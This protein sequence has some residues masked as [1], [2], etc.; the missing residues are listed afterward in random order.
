MR[1]MFL[2]LAL[3]MTTSSLMADTISYDVTLDELDNGSYALT[4][5]SALFQIRTNGFSTGGMLDGATSPGLSGGFDEAFPE[6]TLEDYLKF[7]YF[8]ILQ[9]LDG[10][11]NVIDSSFIVALLPGSGV[12][13]LVQDLFPY[14]EE[15]LVGAFVTFDS[16][17]FID[18]LDK[19]PSSPVAVGD[20]AIPSRSGETLDLIAFIG[21]IDGNEGVKVGTLSF[22]V[23]PEVSSI[24]STSILA[25]MGIAGYAV[26]RARSA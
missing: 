26:R 18:M 24:F 21:G 5:Q 8:G 23:V 19:V 25:L 20:I 17:Q 7:G 2:S 16:P 10:D 13:S 15:T 4:G 3:L 14:L 22:A 9:T 1:S 11:S 6:P 12:G